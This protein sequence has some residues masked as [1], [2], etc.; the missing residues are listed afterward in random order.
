MTD[1]LS[2]EELQALAPP[3]VSTDTECQVAV[4]IATRASKI[5]KI[6]DAERAAEVKPLNDQVKQINAE[7]KAV[8][9]PYTALKETMDGHVK[10]F[11]L[12]QQQARA[13]EALA[14]ARETP[15][16][17]PDGT[18]V[19]N[20]SATD[21]AVPTVSTRETV[22]VDSIDLSLLPDE[23]W[24]PDMDKINA[25]IAAGI[26][27]PGVKINVKTTIIHR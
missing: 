27:I 5:A 13:A 18:P 19:V 7:Y 15:K 26:A 11:L 16:F 10:V 6:L 2:I 9:A 24:K 1:I 21:I 4:D 12:Q 22:V 25:A 17:T 23:Y 20:T 3:S 14:R 8:I